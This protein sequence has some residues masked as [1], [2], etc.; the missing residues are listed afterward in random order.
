MCPRTLLGIKEV[1][2]ILS[3]FYQNHA[4]ESFLLFPQNHCTMKIST[5]ENGTTE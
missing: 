4:C 2:P 5:T 3:L 1:K